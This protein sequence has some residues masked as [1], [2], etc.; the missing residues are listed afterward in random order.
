MSESYTNGNGWHGQFHG[1]LLGIHRDL[2]AHFD[3]I[4]DVQ[5][6]GFARIGQGLFIA[7]AP[8]VATLEGARRVPSETPILE[9]ILFDDNLEDVGFHCETSF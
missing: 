7:V 5:L 6:N 8:S 4:L 3:Q 9:L 1:A 2:L